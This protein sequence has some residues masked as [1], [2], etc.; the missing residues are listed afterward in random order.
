MLKEPGW[1]EPLI[2]W[3]LN[4]CKRNDLEP[5]VLVRK[6]KKDLIDYLDKNNVKY[7]VMK[8][9][10]E[11]AQTVYNSKAHWNDKNILLL[12]DVRFKS[13]K[14]LEDIKNL[15]DF[16]SEVIFAVHKVNNLS[17]WGFVNINQYSEKPNSNE[18]GTAWG[19]IGFTKYAGETIFRNMQR[20]GEYFWHKDETNFVFL[21]EFKDITRNEI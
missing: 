14:A 3:T 11:W 8:P 21:E 20:K 6:E 1:D 13:L 5:L 16:G 19:I 18:S 4:Q 17:K 7:I 10:Q 12:P 2:H 9:G 15:L